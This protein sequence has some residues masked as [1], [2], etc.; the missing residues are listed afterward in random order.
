MSYQQGPVG[1]TTPQIGALQSSFGG[2]KSMGQ[3]LGDDGQ[4]FGDGGQQL[5]GGQHD[6]GGQLGIEQQLTSQGA[7]Q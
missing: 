3:Q 7:S 1:P 5:T 4:Q 2:Q 6:D